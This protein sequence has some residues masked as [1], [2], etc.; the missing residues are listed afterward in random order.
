M[1]EK[2]AHL[3]RGDLAEQEERN[4][5]EPDRERRDEEDDEDGREKKL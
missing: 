3:G 1:I 2:R 5:T 4:R